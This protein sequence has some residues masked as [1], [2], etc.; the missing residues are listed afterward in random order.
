VA[1]TKLLK[2][3]AAADIQCIFD[4]ACIDKLATIG[5]LPA[6]ADRKRFAEGVREAAGIYAREARAPTD[7]ELHA[8]IATLYRA[9]ECK[10]C[11][12]L[13]DLLEKISPKA[14]ELLSKRD[15][16][17]PRTARIRRLAGGE[18]SSEGLRNNLEGVS[19][20]RPLHGRSPTPFG[21]AVPHLASPAHRAEPSPQF[22]K[23]GRGA[24][25]CHVA[26]DRVARDDWQ[27]AKRG[28]Q[29]C[30]TRPF[31]PNGRRIFEVGR[32]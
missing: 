14:R 23:A 20:W 11:G 7:N 18:A 28:G 13:A 2:P 26:A 3:I 24:K 22:S 27:A 10:R 9:A 8:E 19:V 12:H 1:N 5:R 4:D 25:F 31:R 17:K 30:E 21:Q 15:P 6:D 29:P 32:S 16:A